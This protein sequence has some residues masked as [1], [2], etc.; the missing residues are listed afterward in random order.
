VIP[1]G[2]IVYTRE[3]LR[4]RV[5]PDGMYR[6]VFF[7]GNYE[8][9]H[10]KIYRR[11][12]RESDVVLDVGANFG[13]FSALFAQWVGEDGRVH[14]FEP[15]PFIHDL[16]VETLALNG[17]ESRVQLNPFG[18]GRE[19]APIS[20]FT[21]AGLP[22][23]HATAFDLGRKDAVQHD[24]RIRRLDEYCEENGIASFRF[25]KVDVEGFEPDVFEGGRKVLSRE[26]APIIA[27]EINSDCLRRRHLRSRDVIE[28]LRALGYTDFYGF[29]IR[30]GVKRLESPD[31]G[32]ADCLAVKPRRMGELA[33]ALRTGRVLR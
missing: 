27:F 1:P 15:V 16:A 6:S 25:M 18:L 11:I 31:F 4:I 29:S 19:N 3:G 32:A 23:G 8:P 33:P 9:Y 7:W 5:M 24:A 30:S 13:W 26:D 28:A 2:K 10:T 20:M 21:Y 12:V 14:S 22:H 17:V